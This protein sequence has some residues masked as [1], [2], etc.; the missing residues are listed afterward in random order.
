MVDDGLPSPRN[1]RN[2]N[3]SCACDTVVFVNE[4]LTL[5][6]LHI[7]VAM[8]TFSNASIRAVPGIQIGF[9]PLKTFALLCGLV[10]AAAVCVAG[11][12]LDLSAGF[13]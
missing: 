2:R 11:F 5:L 12:G 6:V 13:F 4:R 7:E 10:L 9:H 3:S 1:S 8:N